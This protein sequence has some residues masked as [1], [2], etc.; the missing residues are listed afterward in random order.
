MSTENEEPNEALLKTAWSLDDPGKIQELIECGADVHYT[1][2]D[3]GDT[4]L[5]KSCS[6][7]YINNVKLLLEKGADVEAKNDEGM[8]SLMF[9]SL[10]GHLETLQYLHR[11]G[12]Q[13]ET[14]NNN[15]WSSIQFASW[16]GH[17]ETV[18]YLHENGAH[19]EENINGKTS[20]MLASLIGCLEVVQYL[21]QKGADVD[22]K[23]HYGQN[24]LMYATFG[25]SSFR[26]SHWITRKERKN[27]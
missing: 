10:S 9:A 8:T 20:M 17:L 21:H 2:P 19:I 16:S 5:I 18:K 27:I 4:P 6:K 23:D 14:K 15:G 24:S 26:K 13:I 1:D 22:A 3:T 12:A 7:G 25:K 11:N